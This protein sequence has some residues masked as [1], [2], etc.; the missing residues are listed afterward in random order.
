MYVRDGHAQQEVGPSFPKKELGS[1][2]HRQHDGGDHILGKYIS[3]TL[4][5]SLIKEVSIY[6]QDDA[7]I[8]QVF[9]PCRSIETLRDL[10]RKELENIEIE[11]SK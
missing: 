4:H 10:I 5:D 6:F 7:L 8:G 3:I 1:R 9:K 2:N 11:F